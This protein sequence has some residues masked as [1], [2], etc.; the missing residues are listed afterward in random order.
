MHY[1]IM[2]WWNIGFLF[3]LVEK[4]HHL[5]SS[6]R[7]DP[8]IPIALRIVRTDPNTLDPEAKPLGSIWQL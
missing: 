3:H 5:F 6:A 4:Y 7:K 8:I 1:G 2:E